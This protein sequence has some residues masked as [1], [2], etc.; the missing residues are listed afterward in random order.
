M[1]ERPVMQDFKEQNSQI[2]ANFPVTR[3]EQFQ[4]HFAAVEADSYSP[5]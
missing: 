4:A 5:A 1:D 3:P 2:W